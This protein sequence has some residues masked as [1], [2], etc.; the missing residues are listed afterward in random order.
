[1]PSTS[2]PHDAH[3]QGP[4]GPAG[5]GDV[6]LLAPQND[7]G[8][9]HVAP[10]AVGLDGELAD[11][12]A[13]EAVEDLAVEGPDVLLM[14]GAGAHPLHLAGPAEDADEGEARLLLSR[15][16]STSSSMNSFMK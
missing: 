9:G 15:S 11:G 10:G 6:D 14:C 5:L 12:Q 4:H 13:A 3:G 2:S 1:M 7:V 16:S 8:D